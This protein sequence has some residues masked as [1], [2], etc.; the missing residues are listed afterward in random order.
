MSV[1]RYMYW[2]C[3]IDCENIIASQSCEHDWFGSTVTNSREIPSRWQICGISLQ[4]GK[5]KV[6]TVL[7]IFIAATNSSTDN[8][9]ELVVGLMQNMKFFSRLL[10]YS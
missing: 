10:I 4:I 6:C 5:F 7:I 8:V 2:V 3:T 1:C 9:Y